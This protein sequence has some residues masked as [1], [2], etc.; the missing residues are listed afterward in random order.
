MEDSEF[1]E[2]NFNMETV[3]RENVEHVT[4]NFIDD[5]NSIIT[6]KEPKEAN[7]YINTFF[8]VLKLYYSTMKLKINDEKTN[9]LVINRPNKENE[10]KEIKLETE[11]NYKPVLPKKQIKVL[12][13]Y[14]NRQMNMNSNLMKVIQKTNLTLNQMKG[15]GRYMSQST[16][17]KFIK[18]HILS[19]IFY[20]LPCYVGAN[21]KT[22]TGLH[23]IIV[24]VYRWARNSYCFKE[25]ISSISK[26]LKLDTPIQTIYKRTVFYFHKILSKRKP[27]QI[28]ELI[29]LPR[30]R[31]KAK[32]SLK[33]KT[34]GSRL[35][36]NMISQAI[37]MYNTLPEDMKRMSVK[38]FKT[39]LKKIQLEPP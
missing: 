12:G 34:K 18:S 26:S 36:R 24:K 9:L 7:P 1:M 10:A 13:W 39:K 5:S 28:C 31:S 29:R 14:M 4:V 2:K 22:K 17:T 11:S 15:V 27:R 6:F 19:R 3:N 16:K 32:L 35:E 23:N 21:T 25:S 30:T 38:D 33:T 8:K 37:K 20:G